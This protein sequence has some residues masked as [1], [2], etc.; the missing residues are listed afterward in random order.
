MVGF[1]KYVK[2]IFLWFYFLF[3]SFF[4]FSVFQDKKIS[5]EVFRVVL[6]TLGLMDHATYIK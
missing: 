1:T 2:E 3:L 5:I 6:T 4:P